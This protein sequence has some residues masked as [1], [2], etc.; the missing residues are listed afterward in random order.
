MGN[1][2]SIL[3]SETDQRTYNRL[4]QALALK[5]R[6]QVFIAVCD[7]L[8]LRN[9]LALQLET[10]L[11]ST[12]QSDFVPE[13]LISPALIS[14]KLDLSNPNPF[15]A[16]TQWYAQNKSDSSNQDMI[17]FQILGVEHLTRQPPAKQWSFLRYLRT[18]ENHVDGLEFSLLLWISSPWLYCIQQSA[19]E[20]WERR[21]GV[22]EWMS[23]PT[24]S[25]GESETISLDY[26][27]V[28]QSVESVQISDP[29]QEL[30]NQ[31]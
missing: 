24:P 1:N 21:T 12:N 9:H 30:L 5:L 2:G 8:N 10:D 6:R 3:V 25:D 7:N 29:V 4:Q 27:T 26:T 22:F 19:P 28:S 31:I 17:G 20:F 23:D 16:I 14:L 11:L 15:Q 13:S 18:L